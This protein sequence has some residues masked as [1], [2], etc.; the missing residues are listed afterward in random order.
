MLLQ[1]IH[2]MS[3]EGINVVKRFGLVS[4]KIDVVRTVFA[5]TTRQKHVTIRT[6]VK[7]QA[8]LEL[9]VTLLSYAGFG[10]LVAT[11]LNISLYTH[12]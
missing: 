12:I 1:V 4:T 2:H 11:F 7:F 9:T 10:I 8:V 5:Y 3:A 6:Y